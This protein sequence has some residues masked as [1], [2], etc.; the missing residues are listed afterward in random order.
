MLRT[1]GKMLS[2]LNVSLP[3]G[4]FSVLLLQVSLRVSDSFLV[5]GPSEPIVV[6]LGADAVLPCYVDPAMSVEN[7]E[8][9]WYR[10]QFSEAVYMYQ[11]GME[12]TGQQLEDFKRRTE[13]VKDRMSEGRVAVK[14]YHVRVSDNGMYRCF[15]RKGSDF[16]EATLELRVVGE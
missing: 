12:Q 16:E 4:L 13:L 10:S 11:D 6:M 7:M 14:I 9:R 1:L 2:S 15:F 8:L 3:G 5:V